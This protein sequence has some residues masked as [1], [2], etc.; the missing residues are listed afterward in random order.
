MGLSKNNWGASC[1]GS[2]YEGSYYFESILDAPDFWKLPY[3]DR[4]GSILK[5]YQAEPRACGMTTATA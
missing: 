1:F 3:K 2:L 5:G 4:M